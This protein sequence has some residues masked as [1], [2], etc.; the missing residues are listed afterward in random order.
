MEIKRVGVVGCGIMGA[1]IT[2][3]CAESGYSVVVSEV[4][5]RLLRKGL[6]SIKSLLIR[7][8]DKGTISQQ[9]MNIILGRIKGVT[10][11][12]EFFDCDLVIEAVAE[13]LEIKKKV[14]VELDKVCP[15]HTILATNTSSLC[16][17]EIAAATYRLDRVLGLHFFNPVSVM[18]LLE[19]VRTIATSDETLKLVK[20]FGESLG[21]TIVIAKDTPG[22]IVNRLLSPFI[23]NAIRMLEAGMATRD[24]IDNAVRLGLNHPMGPLQLADLIGLDTI[25]NS[26]N[27]RYEELKEAYYAPPPLLKRMVKAGWLGRKTGKGFYEYDK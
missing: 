26:A 2:Q 21:K 3:I 10:E 5:Q 12:R 13:N 20:V 1:G 11:I 18:K 8:V 9:D 25:N 22:F 17:I 16:V 6:A 27:S 4:S 24:D 14:F 19:I 7:S 23:L 15:K